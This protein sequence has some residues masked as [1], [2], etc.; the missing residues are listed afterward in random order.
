MSSE[1][2]SEYS[3]IICPM[4]T[5][6][7]NGEI[8][9][10]SLESVVE[11]LVDGGV[12][13]LM[14]CGTTGEFAALSREEYTAVV[15]RTIEAAD[16][17][18][19]TVPGALSPGVDESAEL[20]DTVTELGADAALVT[21]PYF[22]TSKRPAG[23]ER[24]FRRVMKRTDLPLLLYN[25]PR[26]TGQVISPET[27][28][29]VA[30]DESVIGLKDSG[31][32]IGYYM[33]IMRDTPDDFLLFQ[34]FDNLLLPGTLLG[35]NGGVVALANAL[36]SAVV[37]VLEA[38]ERGDPEAAREIHENQLIPLFE[39]CYDY[40][41]ATVSKAILAKEGVIASDEVRPPL[42]ELVDDELAEV[43]DVLE[44]L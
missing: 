36:P 3:G 4:V 23:N 33:K 15:E 38:S 28:A 12:T 27:V 44:A 37:S 2:D 5:P 39:L 11:F 20:I 29:A 32:D 7:E 43:D 9:L 8:D 26:F 16:G 10:E 14:P 18:A 6:F 17:R 21:N 22:Y 40:G 31:G 41:F 24:F 42:L 30:T 13:G 19:V 35:G 1:L 34:G 25:Q